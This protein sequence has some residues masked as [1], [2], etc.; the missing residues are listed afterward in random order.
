MSVRTVL[1]LSF[2]AL[3]LSQNLF[4]GTGTVSF[5]NTTA[6]TAT[7]GPFNVHDTASLSV[8]NTLPVSVCIVYAAYGLPHPTQY[9]PDNCLFFYNSS[10]NSLTETVPLRDQAYAIG[11]YLN[12]PNAKKGDNTTVSVTLGGADCVTQ[13]WDGAKCQAATPLTGFGKFSATFNKGETKFFT[14]TAPNYVGTLKVAYAAGSDINSVNS[15]IWARFSAVPSKFY[16]DAIETGG[17]LTVVSPRPGVWVIGIHAADAGAGSFVLDGLVCGD[18][19]GGVGCTVPVDPIDNIAEAVLF[20]GP[21][22]FRVVA[23]SGYPFRVSVTSTNATTGIP[24]LYASRGVIPTPGNA[25]V[26]N[27][28]DAY[29]DVV[30]TITFN[31]T[32][33]DEEWF[34]GVFPTVTGNQTYGIWW[35]TTC[36]TGCQTDNHGTCQPSGV[37]ECEIDF[38]GVACSIS[39]GLGPQYIVLI[40]I[41]SLV[42]ASAIIGFVAWAYMRRKRSAYEIVA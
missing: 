7:F 33:A 1:F 41:A 29:C 27:C 6:Y 22:Y 5:D 23:V 4:Q 14:Y 24:Q 3:S 20:N 30:R 2:V 32:G 8:T 34:V 9:H 26:S 16:Y 15:V 25:D 40:I 42:V 39:K 28:N 35:N 31:T 36:I 37:C 11:V 19:S 13:Y 21:Q 12:S 18:K 38:E 10:A 17:N